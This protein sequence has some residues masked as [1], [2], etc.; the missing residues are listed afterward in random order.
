MSDDG[1][2]IGIRVELHRRDYR[3][4][5]KPIV[6]N[7]AHAVRRVSW[8]EAVAPPWGGIMLALKPNKL[9]RAAHPR[10][11]DWVVIRDGVDPN[12]PAM[13]FGHVADDAGRVSVRPDDAAIV[14]GDIAVHAESWLAALHRALLYVTHDPSTSV[15]TIYSMD[16]RWALVTAIDRFDGHVGRALEAI[17]RAVAYVPMPPSLGGRFT[18]LWRTP[19]WSASDVAPP[20][21]APVER[22]NVGDITVFKQPIAL[23]ETPPPNVLDGQVHVY[24]VDTYLANTVG[25]IF[26]AP[27]AAALS[28]PGKRE[29]VGA[30]GREADE[31]PGNRL[32][33]IQSLT[34][35]Q[36]V[37][38][39][40]ILNGT[41]GADPNLVEMFASMED[42]GTGGEAMPPNLV[43]YQKLG[44]RLPV[45]IFRMRPWRTKPI[46]LRRPDAD[47]AAPL[48]ETQE[49]A[50]DKLL[51]QGLKALGFKTIEPKPFKKV[52]WRPDRAIALRA[53][54]GTVVEYR[55]SL[56]NHY[57][58][59]TCN[60][61]LA[62]GTPLGYLWQAGLPIYDAHEVARFGAKLYEVNWP[63]FG[64]LG[65]ADD[66][67]AMSDLVSWPRQKPPTA[68]VLHDTD[69]WT[70]DGAI[71]WW[72]S[73]RNPD[74]A[75][76]NYMIDENGVT[77]KLLDPA[78]Y[79]ARHTGGGWNEVAIGIDLVVRPW[80]LNDSQASGRVVPWSWGDPNQNASYNLYVNLGHPP[81]AGKSW[82]VDYTQAQKDALVTLLNELHET[83]GI[84][85]EVYY[86]P[87]LHTAAAD[88]VTPLTFGG[89]ISHGQ[90]DAHNDG[91]QAVEFL[92]TGLGLASFDV[93]TP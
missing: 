26:D 32:P 89:V 28:G 51:N 90:I 21:V 8:G 64:Q 19:T 54:D 50:A 91:R 48:T 42:V 3:D 34:G 81:D 31:V 78:L 46:K 35:A 57:N 63:F 85:L 79:C 12:G 30:P 14:Q 52:T 56:D 69:G 77:H 4:P 7:V 73:P 20:S 24:L 68:I 15:G 11:G 74:R 76:T 41:F 36:G 10:P 2:V 17:F 25:I 45:L 70:M 92:R 84:P 82:V 13:A 49:E 33:D 86:P 93:W 5:D 18:E 75:S 72:R 60:F 67:G 71:S 38:A 62:P 80:H 9:S 59:A 29:R 88:G 83:F 39:L 55:R 58:A 22:V 66:P 16:Q 87:K 23:G 47:A 6:H 65:D 37:S 53:S 44:K 1:T 61:A 43:L 40:D 27:T